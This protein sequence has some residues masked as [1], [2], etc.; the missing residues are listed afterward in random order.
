MTN[1]I[2]ASIRPHLHGTFEIAKKEGRRMYVIRQWHLSA[3]CINNVIT[4]KR[5]FMRTRQSLAATLLFFMFSGPL[6]INTARSQVQDILNLDSAAW[7]TALRIDVEDIWKGLPQTALFNRADSLIL[8]VGRGEWR[9]NKEGLVSR[10]PTTAGNE[11]YIYAIKYYN[12][13]DE[14]HIF[15]VQFVADSGSVVGTSD[16]S[17]EKR[18]LDFQN[19][20]LYRVN[21]QHG[22]ATG[23]AAP[24]KLANP[25]WEICA[26]SAGLMELSADGKL[27]FNS[28]KQHDLMDCLNGKGAIDEWLN[29]VGDAI[30][31]DLDK[32]SK[33]LD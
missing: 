13:P 30:F 14:L 17:G 10:I 20:Y 26:L 18:V 21:Y 29:A 33:W 6:F 25:N 2:D 7:N 5:G 11:Q 3:Y 31:G 12:K 1:Q 16:F 8:F 15:S 28:G 23:T 24:V 9:Y 22:I 19:W 27:I 32:I 4:F